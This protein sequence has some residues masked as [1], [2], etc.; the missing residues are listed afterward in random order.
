MGERSAIRGYK[1]QYDAAAYFSARAL[2]ERQLLEVRLADL[3]VGRVDDLVLV[4]ASG[5]VHGYQMKAVE[6]ELSFND[7]TRRD[8]LLFQLVPMRFAHLR[9]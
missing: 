1:A 2:R 4:L 5:E 7:F 8:G 3:E 6:G 9:A